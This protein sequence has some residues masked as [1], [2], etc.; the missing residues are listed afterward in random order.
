MPA[1]RKRSLRQ[2]R[3]DAENADGAQLWTSAR[4]A[5]AFGAGVSSVKRWTDDGELESVRT[6]GGHRRYTM[7]ALH[8]FAS[9]RGLPVDGLPQAAP[10]ARAQ[11]PPPARLTLFKALVQG[12][13][14]AVR[15]LIDPRN[16]SVAQRATFL[17]RTAGD[18]LR[19]I[20]ERWQ[21]G[22]L[23]VEEEHRASHL[24]IEAI[25]SLRPRASSQGPLALLA[26]PPSEAH[27]LPLHLVRLLL[28]WSGW[29][30]QL[31]GASLPWEAAV[32]AA[33]RARPQ[34]FAFSARSGEAFRT[35]RFAAFAR[36]CAAL[37]AKVAVGGE[38]ARGSVCEPRGV[39]RFRTLKGFERW[40]RSQ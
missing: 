16:S 15:A 8:R 5:R 39:L 10:P 13:E 12:D 3:R 9:A 22:R 33:K 17:D 30:T 29:R 1:V 28:E 23:G 19:Q 35:P 6:P 37:G 14:A 26:C 11:K 25:D 21:Q 27:D 36:D 18:A 7:A 4:V 31:L 24:L 32:A 20:G 34:L 2:I 38:W 40:L